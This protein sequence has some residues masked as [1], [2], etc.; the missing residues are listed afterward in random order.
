[1]VSGKFAHK[2]QILWV[3]GRRVKV[4][5]F[6]PA[7]TKRGYEVE[8]VRSGKAAQ[9]WLSTLKADLIVLYAAS[10]GTSGCRMAKSL[11]EVAP[12]T[13][14]L[15]I[16]SPE[17]P[18]KPHA[19]VNQ[20]L[21]LPFTSR[22]LLNRIRHLL[23]P[24]ERRWFKVGKVALDEHNG[25]VHCHGKEHRLT[26]R[27]T[28]LLKHFMENPNKVIPYQQL[29]SE[30]WRTSYLGDTRTLQVHIA[31]LR[32]IL[33]PDPRHPRFIETLRG[34]G[35]RFHPNGKELPEPEKD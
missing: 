19:P 15:L 10:F 9:E 22:K 1:M 14:I 29:F 20:T 7:L 18:P 8:V 35:Y 3:E 4:P 12:D 6:V 17:S 21:V 31:W 28:A 34:I 30:V 5:D 2:K 16:A 11:R 13:P 23:P 26:P 25:L 32:R 24:H 33:E 27:L